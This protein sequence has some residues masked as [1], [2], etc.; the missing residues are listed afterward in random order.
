[1][2]AERD[3]DS[4]ERIQKVLARCG[5]GSRRQCDELVAEGRI[6]VNGSIALPG[7]RVVEGDVIAVDGVEIPSEPDI[8]VYLLNKPAGVITTSADT[9]GRPTVIELVPA[10]PRVFSVGR[11]DAD[12]EGVLL[13]TNDGDF[14]NR[15][16]HPSHG[17]EKEYLAEVEGV[18]S[19]GELRTLREGVDLEDGPT[20]PASVRLVQQRD[21]TAV[22]ELIIHEG[23]NRQVRRMCE[24]IGHPVIRLV[25][26]R[27]GPLRATGVTPGE[28]RQL[29]RTEVVD[30]L[31]TIGS[32]PDTAAE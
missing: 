30:V 27:V 3:A 8:V 21:D 9:H 11:L 20:A 24:A 2:T 25:R 15:V 12:T 7:E 31:R 1:V 16:A 29:D 5:V 28:W 6:T 26:T 14:A 13:L 22:I 23:R 4:G 32:G 10:E 19:R 17:V 18:V